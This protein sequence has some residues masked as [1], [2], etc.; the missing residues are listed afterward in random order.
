MRRCRDQNRRAGPWGQAVVI[1][2]VN[3]HRHQTWR[4]HISPRDWCWANRESVPAAP[5]YD[6]RSQ[7]FQQGIPLCWL[8]SSKKC[9]S[10]GKALASNRFEYVLMSL[11]H[12]FARSMNFFFFSVLYLGVKLVIFCKLFTMCKSKNLKFWQKV[13]YNYFVKIMTLA[14]NLYNNQIISLIKQIL[15]KISQLV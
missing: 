1:L 9:A 10:L 7:S 8:L 15:M 11:F 14:P 4:R 13:I 5:V 2:R 3:G 12:D 6:I